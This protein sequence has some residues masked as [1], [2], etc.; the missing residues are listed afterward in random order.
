LIGDDVAKLKNI[1]HSDDACTLIFKG[2][3][4]HPEPA[5]GI[6][7]FPGGHVEVS[8]TSDGNYW[9]HLSFDEQASVV[10][11]RI[12]YNHEG[13]AATGGSIPDVPH[14]DKIQHFAFLVK[15][16]YLESGE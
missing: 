3:I 10:G 15:G 16:K 12:D 4:K 5:T 8:R 7:K 2:D 11:S 1:V 13:Y 6:I 14:A 9:A